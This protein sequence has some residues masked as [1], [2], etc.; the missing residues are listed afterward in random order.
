V[1][2]FEKDTQPG[3]LAKSISVWGQSVEVGPHYLLE[4]PDTGMTALLNDALGSAPMHRYLRRTSILVDGRYIA[5]PPSARSLLAGLGPWAS[6]RGGISFLGQLVGPARQSGS[7]E[8]YISQRVGPYF[9]R[10]LFRDYSEKLWGTPC[11]T[12]DESYGRSLIGFGTQSLG[13]TLKKYLLPGKVHAHARCLYPEAGMSALWHG[14]TRRIREQGGQ[15]HFGARVAQVIQGSSGA[16]GLRLEDGSVRHYDRI[17][18]TI[19][20]SALL[21]LLSD[22][23]APLMS[24]MNSVRYRSL[25]A[26]FCRAGSWEH[27]RHHSVFLYG[28][29]FR[30][31]RITNF[32]AFRGLPGNDVLLLEYWTDEGSPLWQASEEEILRVVN[33]DLGRF[34]GSLPATVSEVTM[35]RLRRAYQV[36]LPDLRAVK[37]EVAGHLRGIA[38]LTL[39]GRANQAQFNYGM[40]DAL[41]EGLGLARTLHP[42]DLKAG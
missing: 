10:R 8:D 41:A 31:A 28:P 3:G 36:P 21:R 39:A 25:L 20:E 18:S 42:Q 4:T 24:R 14:L 22:P 33:E 1:E 32:N 23:P 5:Y 35:V 19:P 7:V 38:G 17:V 6:F 12:L 13:A 15:V 29:E 26:V 16:Q 37:D 9:Y 2:V 27:L 34:P 30:A 11:R 40:A